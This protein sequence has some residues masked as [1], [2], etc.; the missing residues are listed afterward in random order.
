MTA[1]VV[2]G[3]LDCSSVVSRTITRGALG[4]HAHEL[5]GRVGR[6]LRMRLLKDPAAAGLQ[7]RRPVNVGHIPSGVRASTA[8]ARVDIALDPRVDG[9]AAAR[10][11]ECGNET[12]KAWSERAGRT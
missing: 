6:I 9:V 5:A 3:I 1:H 7:D 8:G 12:E 10:E 11:L 4:S 2:D